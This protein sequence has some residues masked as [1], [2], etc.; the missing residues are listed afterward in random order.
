MSKDVKEVR[1]GTVRISGRKSTIG[2]EKSKHKGCKAG[3][4]LKMGNGER[5]AE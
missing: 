5:P 4:W 2:R 3:A 1:E